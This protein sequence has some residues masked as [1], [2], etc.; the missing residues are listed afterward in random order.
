MSAGDWFIYSAHERW[1]CCIL[2]HANVKFLL[3]SVLKVSYEG[4]KMLIGTLTCTSYAL[5][6]GNRVCDCKNTSCLWLCVW[7]SAVSSC[8]LHTSSC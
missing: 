8:R 5:V 7:V 2:V 4:V 1:L 3:G 6:F